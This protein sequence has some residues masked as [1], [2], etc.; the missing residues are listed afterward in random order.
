MRH[1]IAISLAA[2]VWIPMG[3]GCAEQKE[4][5]AVSD[6]PMIS[7]MTYFAAGQVLEHQKDLMGAIHQYSK[8]IE[9]EPRLTR[10]YN[11]LGLIFQRMNRIEDAQLI[12]MQGIEENPKCAILRNNFGFCSLQ[13]NNYTGAEQQFRKALE[14]SPKFSQAWMNLGISLA[15]QARFGESVASFQQVVPVEVAYTNV[16]SICISMEDYEHAAWAL[17]NALANNPDYAPAKDQVDHV[18]RLAQAAREEAE[19]AQKQ[20]GWA[21]LASYP[22]SDTSDGHSMLA[23]PLGDARFADKESAG[24]T[25]EGEKGASV[26]ADS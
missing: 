12:L 6:E 7:P 11:R 26:N 23:P 25:E 1:P 18:T 15:R 10:A 16:A 14:I 9:A 19:T 13:K 8:A 22:S 20:G 2:L 4:E 17:R 5:V 21:S 3:L 24:P